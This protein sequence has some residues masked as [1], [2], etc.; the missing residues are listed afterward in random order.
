MTA[1]SGVDDAHGA[2]AAEL[3]FP[4][5]LLTIERG[6]A[7]VLA[8]A[9]RDVAPAQEDS[10]VA[11]ARVAEAVRRSHD[12]VVEVERRSRHEPARRGRLWT[13]RRSVAYA[14]E[15]GSHACV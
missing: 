12:R 9:G 5:A 10:D 4:P 7:S 8:R 14:S 2:A 1:G 6:A 13:T 3:R 15:K 11:H